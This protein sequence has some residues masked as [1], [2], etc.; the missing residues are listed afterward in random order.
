[1]YQ[2]TLAAD[3]ITPTNLTPVHTNSVNMAGAFC[4]SE[5]PY[6]T[7]NSQFHKLVEMVSF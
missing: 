2:I 7:E 6:A 4:T 1:M 5:Q 3:G